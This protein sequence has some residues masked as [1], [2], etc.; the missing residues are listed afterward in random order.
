MHSIRWRWESLDLSRRLPNYTA[1]RRRPR[2]EAKLP[3]EA[4][5][6]ESHSDDSIADWESLWIDL[7]GEG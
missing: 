3:S 6:L 2:P 7:G 5:S 1:E 4:A